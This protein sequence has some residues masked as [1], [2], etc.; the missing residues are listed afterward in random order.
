MYYESGM[1][2]SKNL[3]MRNYRAFSLHGKGDSF[4][5][6]YTRAEPPIYFRN[7]RRRKDKNPLFQEFLARNEGTIE[8]SH[9][10]NLGMFRTSKEAQLCLDQEKEKNNKKYKL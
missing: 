3:K 10:M 9:L 5:Y 4:Y 1:P 8:T 6:F 7:A 2:Y